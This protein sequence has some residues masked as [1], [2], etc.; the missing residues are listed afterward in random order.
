MK[1]IKS[2]FPLNQNDYEKGTSLLQEYEYKG[3]FIREFEQKPCDRW[4][5][6][7]Q[8]QDGYDL[9]TGDEKGEGGYEILDHKGEII[10]QDFYCMG[11]SATCNAEN[12]ID[13]LVLESK[14]KKLGI[15]T[16]GKSFYEINKEINGDDLDKEQNQ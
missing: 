16:S 10:E 6:A 12:E 8:S 4:I 15:E 3:Y 13:F 9:L 2:R 5:E 11:D 7:M 14:A 1:T